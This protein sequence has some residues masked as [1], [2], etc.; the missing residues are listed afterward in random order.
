MLWKSLINS[1][2]G[3]QVDSI[4]PVAKLDSGPSRMARLAQ[5]DAAQQVAEAAALQE[6][7]PPEA[8]SVLR[9]LNVARHTLLAAGIE[10][11]SAA[12][13]VAAYNRATSILNAVAESGPILPPLRG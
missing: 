12:A 7:K 6:P 10:A 13:A 5:I 1:V 2:L 9:D 8:L 4:G 3:K 11:G